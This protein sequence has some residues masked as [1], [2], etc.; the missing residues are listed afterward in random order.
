MLACATGL[1]LLFGSIYMSMDDHK[2]AHFKRFY[3]M[4]DRSQKE[5]YQGIVKERMMIYVMGMVLG[6][7]LGF[8]YYLKNPNDRYRLCKLLCIIYLVKLGFYYVYPK[9]PLMLYSLTE[10]RQVEAWA[11]IYTHMKERW[12]TS[13]FVGF[14]GYLML[15][16]FAC[17]LRL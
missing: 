13:L 5:T 1:T 16:W 14:I 3:Q 9:K 4:L 10:E 6:L 17:H 8:M 12:I 11:D 15:G 7:V 2:S